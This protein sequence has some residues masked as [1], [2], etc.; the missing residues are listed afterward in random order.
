MMTPEAP[1]YKTTLVGFEYTD[2]QD[3][4]NTYRIYCLFDGRILWPVSKLSLSSLEKPPVLLQ[5][6][7]ISKAGV[8]WITKEFKRQMRIP[9][10]Q[11]GEGLNGETYYRHY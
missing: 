10:H 5:T 2:P 8:I 6:K 7:R 9:N 11:P 4:S 1:V 3:L